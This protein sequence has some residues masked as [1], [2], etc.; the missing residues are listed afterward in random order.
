VG[1]CVLSTALL[2]LL[3]DGGRIRVPSGDSHKR[4]DLTVAGR[5]LILD[6]KENQLL[7]WCSQHLQPHLWEKLQQ[8]SVF[9][10]TKQVC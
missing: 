5:R 2:A 1:G 9:V 3:V 4:Y 7:D 10:I 6:K 8:L